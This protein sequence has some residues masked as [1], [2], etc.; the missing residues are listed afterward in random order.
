ML[1]VERFGLTVIL[2]MD[3]LRRALVGLTPRSKGQITFTIDIHGRAINKQ[4][5]G[6]VVFPAM[7]A[8]EVV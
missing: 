7:A 1:D 2:A 8:R 5:V 4:G 3:D 6:M